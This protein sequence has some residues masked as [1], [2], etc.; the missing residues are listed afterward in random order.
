MAVL[1]EEERQKLSGNR[2]ILKILKDEFKN[3]KMK[4][5]IRVSSKQKD[6]SL[7]VDK[8]GNVLQWYQSLNPELRADPAIQNIMNQIL[9]SSGLSAGSL[10]GLTS[11]ALTSAPSAPVEANK[12]LREL[13]RSRATIT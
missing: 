8:L 7:F 1:E 4:V 6:M 13:S 3:V 12:P 10:S 9:E 5:K 11:G 2:Q